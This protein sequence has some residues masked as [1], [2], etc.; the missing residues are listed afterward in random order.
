M[1]WNTQSNRHKLRNELLQID[2]NELE[3]LVKG[4]YILFLLPRM[5]YPTDTL[6]LRPWTSFTD[7]IR[8]VIRGSL[9][10]DNDTGHVPLLHTKIKGLS[11][12]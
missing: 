4:I 10:I 12:N 2:P 6:N 9:T 3:K 11:F 1:Y 8:T 5:K 7:L